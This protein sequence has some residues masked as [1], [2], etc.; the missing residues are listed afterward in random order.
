MRR[1]NA[2]NEVC[3]E[4]TNDCPARCIHCSSAHQECSLGTLDTNMLLR[5]MHDLAD[6]G[7]SVVELSGGE[8]LL[9]PDVLALIQCAKR[10]GVESRL[11]TS[12]LAVEADGTIDGISA[13]LA[14]RLRNVGLCRVIFNL[15][16]A[17]AQVHEL[18]NRVP[19][20]FDL[21]VRGIRNAK[22]A[23]LWVGIHFVPMQPNAEELPQ[24]LELARSLGVDEVAVLRFVP[25]G[26]G[27]VNRE[28]LQLSSDE[29]ASLVATT[30][31]LVKRYR[32]GFVRLGS[33]MN[34]CSFLNSSIPPVACA[35]GVSTLTILPDGRVIPCPAFKGLSAY[36]A[37][38]VQEESLKD[39]WWHS[40]AWREF[41]AFSVEKLRGPCASCQYLPWC[42]GRCSAQRIRFWGDIYQGPDP[43]CI[44]V[45]WPESIPERV[46]TEVEA[47]AA[48]TFVSAS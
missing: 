5:A 23:G 45:H 7:A 16:G 26:R 34:F 13:E 15:Q 9:H 24:L 6:L 31:E 14:E 46:A 37:G 28:R 19:G 30:S 29:F 27:F 22:L 17:F 43:D 2:L 25:Q 3:L 41:R 10:L 11:Y 18:I 12:G 35:A 8:P 42:Q 39:I 20:S 21:V 4:I 40:P 44:V 32:K 47:A 48:G 33:P 38:T 36:V 1:S